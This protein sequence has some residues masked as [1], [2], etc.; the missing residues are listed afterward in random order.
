MLMLQNFRCDYALG[1]V[2][3]PVRPA[4]GQGAE[5]DEPAMW[6][7]QFNPDERAILTV[8]HVAGLAE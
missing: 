6:I 7:V 8:P 1:C 4:G 2:R 3:A 5:G